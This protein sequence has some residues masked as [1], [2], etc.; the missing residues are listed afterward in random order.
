[1]V[2]IKDR[3]IIDHLGVC[4]YIQEE[5]CEYK[6]LKDLNCCEDRGS[7]WLYR[8]PNRLPRG[9]SCIIAGLIYHPPKGDGSFIHHHLFQT[10]ALTEARYSNCG[11]LVTGDFNCLNID[12]LLN[13]LQLKQIVKVPTRKKGRLDLILTNMHEYYSPSQAYSPLGLSD[14]NAV[15]ATPKDGKRNINSKKVT[16]RRNL[17]TS[18]KAAL[19][20]YLMQVNWPLLFT[21]LVSCEEKWQ[22]FQDVIHS[23]LDTIMPAKPVKIST[24]DVPW[25]NE[26]LKSLIVKRQKAFSAYGPDSAQPRYFRNLVNRER[27]TCRGKCYKSKIHHS[28]GENPKRWW[29][30]VKRL[31]GLKT[32]HSELASQI[33][34]EGVSELPFKEQAN[35]INSALLEPLTEYKLPAPLERVGLECD[36]TEVFRV[37][38]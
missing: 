25:M 11:L 22:V 24:A 33:K 13:H 17:Q 3:Q 23:G 5:N 15:V 10:L 27:K 29:D 30:E 19:G 34:I 18:N 36:S 32:Y 35:A 26:S 38:E 7:T 28:K 6:Q 31:N 21:P 37:T 4:A 16:V 2:R 9:Y 1:M 20:R 12:G 8:R 14:P